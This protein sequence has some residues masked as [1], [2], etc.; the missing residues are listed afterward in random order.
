MD[1]AS[2]PAKDAPIASIAFP[3]LINTQ[4]PIAPLPASPHNPDKRIRR[5]IKIQKD[6]TTIGQKAPQRYC[7]KQHGLHATHC[8][9]R[10][11][12]K[13]KA[14]ASE[15]YAEWGDEGKSQDLD[16]VLPRWSSR[17]NT[18][19]RHLAHGAPVTAR[20]SSIIINIA[21]IYHTG[22]M[23]SGHLYDAWHLW[24]QQHQKCGVRAM[25]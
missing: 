17:T 13:E 25:Q 20:K 6:E 4:L 21:Y 5:K 2:S 18:W 12:H 14:D 24:Q 11:G 16:K 22:T 3:T 19:P 9:I 10:W 15:R 7:R 8:Y 1:I 23:W